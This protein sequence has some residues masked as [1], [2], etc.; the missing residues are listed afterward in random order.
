MKKHDKSNPEQINLSR[1]KAL[2]R[3]GLVATAVYAAPALMTLSQSAHASPT[4]PSAPDTS[5]PSTSAPSTSTPSVSSPSV[6]SPSVSAPSVSA[7]SAPS[8]SAPSAPSS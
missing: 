4:T 6:G 8:V 5:T 3:L 1:R 2:S 7:P